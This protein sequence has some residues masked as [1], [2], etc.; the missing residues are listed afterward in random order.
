MNVR[1]SDLYQTNEDAVQALA[2][3]RRAIDVAKVELTRLANI[4]QD[5]T[6]Q[7]AQLAALEQ[8]AA[9][10]IEHF[11]PGSAARYARQARQGQL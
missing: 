7:Q 3:I 9:L 11:G 10:F 1:A 4:G 5:V 6:A 2:E 8:Q